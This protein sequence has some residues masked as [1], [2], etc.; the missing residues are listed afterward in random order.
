[1][2][3]ATGHSQGQPEQILPTTAAPEKNPG[4]RRGQVGPVPEYFRVPLREPATWSGSVGSAVRRWSALGD[5]SLW[6]AGDAAMRSRAAWLCHILRGWVCLTPRFL[7]GTRNCEGSRRRRR[8]RGQFRCGSRL[9]GDESDPGLR[10][11]GDLDGGVVDEG[12]TSAAGGGESAALGVVGVVLRRRVDDVH[13]RRLAMAAT[14][15]GRG[16]SWSSWSRASAR[17]SRRASTVTSVP[18]GM[19]S[20]SNRAPCC[21][22]EPSVSAMSVCPFGLA[23]QAGEFLHGVGRLTVTAGTT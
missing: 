7:S 20:R 16:S 17:T 9:V 5:L 10:R 19:P 18:V 12:P 21:V 6:P 8:C 4:Y 11:A 3:T 1:M 2:S 14:F 15:D 23:G 13:S 22:V